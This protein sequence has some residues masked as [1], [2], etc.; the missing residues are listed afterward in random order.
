MSP[1]IPGNPGS[2]F[3]VRSNGDMKGR[4]R[5]SEDDIICL[6]KT[7]SARAKEKDHV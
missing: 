2:Y 1:E 7:R 5:K 4:R 3:A 6:V